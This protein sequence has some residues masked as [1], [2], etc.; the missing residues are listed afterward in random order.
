MVNS[1]FWEATWSLPSPL[2]PRS[3]FG[4]LFRHCPALSGGTIPLSEVEDTS[5]VSVFSRILSA[6]KP[7]VTS[8]IFEHT[9]LNPRRICK[10]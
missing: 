8:S 4:Q 2:K 9:I 1:A 3:H 6:S 5:G 10:S 7:L